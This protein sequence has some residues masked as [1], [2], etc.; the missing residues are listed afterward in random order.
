MRCQLFVFPAT[1]TTSLYLLQGEALWRR[2]CNKRKLQRSVNL[3]TR[4]GANFVPV[5][6]AKGNTEGSMENSMIHHVRY[7]WSEERCLAWLVSLVLLIFT[8]LAATRH[9]EGPPYLTL[10]EIIAGGSAAAIAEII[11]YPI[12]VLK[13]R[14]QTGGSRTSL[15]SWHRPGVVAGTIRALS[16]HGL[17]LGLFPAVKRLLGDSGD[18]LITKLFV[19]AACGALGALIVNPLDLAKTRLQRDPKRYTNS[20]DALLSLPQ[21]QGGAW[22]GANAAIIRASAGTSAQLVAYDMTKS[23]FSQSPPLVG[24][25]LG[26]IVAS[27]AYVTA[28][29]PFDLVKSRIMVAPSSKN[30]DQQY[31]SFPSCFFHIYRNEGIPGLFRGWFPAFLRLLPTTLLVFPLLERFRIFLGAGAF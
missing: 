24:V 26:A 3:R 29:A 20:F 11:L 12:E 6:K 16:Y 27:A 7:G 23:L 21:Q 10:R 30:I 9:F 13:V 31:T 25:L 18:D 2:V 19:G 4:K 5:T 17:R 15:F 1:L 8:G 22:V 28:A 14:L